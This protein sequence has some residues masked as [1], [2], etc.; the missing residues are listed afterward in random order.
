MD[1]KVVEEK[2]KEEEEEEGKFVGSIGPFSALSCVH[3]D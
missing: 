3:C 1:Q 2:K